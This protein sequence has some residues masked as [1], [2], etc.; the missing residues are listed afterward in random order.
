LIISIFEEFD[1]FMRELLEQGG[2]TDF[3]FEE[4]LELRPIRLFAV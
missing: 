1:G 4:V 3:A 2:E